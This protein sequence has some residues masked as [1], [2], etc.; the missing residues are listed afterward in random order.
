MIFKD[1]TKF[2]ICQ[3]SA[4]TPNLRT[5]SEAIR[6][7]RSSPSITRDTTEHRMKIMDRLCDYTV[8]RHMLSEMEQSAD[9]GKEREM[10]TTVIYGNK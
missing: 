9:D 8:A 10:E 1:H 7:R 5:E 6:Q 4:Y 2:I 3:F